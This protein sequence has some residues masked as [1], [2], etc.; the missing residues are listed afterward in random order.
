MSAIDPGWRL[1]DISKQFDHYMMHF[2]ESLGHAYPHSGLSGY[3]TGL[4]LTF[5]RKS[6]G[7]CLFYEIF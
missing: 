4:I 6:V 5:F 2:A 1:M 3:C 7:A